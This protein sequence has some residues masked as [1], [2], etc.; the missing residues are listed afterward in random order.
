MTFELWRAGASGYEG[1]GVGR[2]DA[3]WHGFYEAHRRNELHIIS[4]EPGR[5]CDIAPSGAPFT[6][7]VLV[8]DADRATVTRSVSVPQA[9]NQTV[10]RVAMISLPVMPAIEVDSDPGVPAWGQDEV[11]SFV[12]HDNTEDG[13]YV[14]TIYGL[15]RYVERT[16]YLEIPLDN[17]RAFP[18]D[19]A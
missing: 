12:P 8:H 4:L 10:G 7:R 14:A 2:V 9:E 1:R 17:I 6:H 16:A 5:S 13:G 15:V 19:K 18:Q 3:V 11:I